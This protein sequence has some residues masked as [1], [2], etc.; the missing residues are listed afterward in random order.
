MWGSTSIFLAN[1]EIHWSHLYI[2]FSPLLFNMELLIMCLQIIRACE[3]FLAYIIFY[4]LLFVALMNA[5]LFMFLDHSVVF[6]C[7]F[8]IKFICLKMSAW[9]MI[10]LFF[11]EI[12]SF[13]TM[14]DC[15]QM[16]YGN[17]SVKFFLLRSNSSSLIWISAYLYLCRDFTRLVPG[18]IPLDRLSKY[19]CFFFFSVASRSN[20][21]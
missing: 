14:V 7:K 11:S 15:A 8:L 5:K 13:V 19:K 1:V 10:F 4:W 9:I 3:H 16:F 17:L 20:L 12:H 21:L 18:K 6:S 2:L